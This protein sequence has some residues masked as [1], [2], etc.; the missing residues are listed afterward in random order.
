MHCKRV[1][2]PYTHA[3][4]SYSQTSR[5]LC[6][7]IQI[8]TQNVLKRQILADSKAKHSTCESR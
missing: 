8:W 4:L 3:V 5:T 1:N 7:L 6:I 2:E